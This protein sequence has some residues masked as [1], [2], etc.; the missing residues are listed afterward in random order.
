VNAITF[1][2]ETTQQFFENP[3]N[4]EG[5]QPMYQIPV[6]AYG[7][8]SRGYYIMWNFICILLTSFVRDISSRLQQAG[9]TYQM[10]KQEIHIELLWGSLWE[11]SHL[12]D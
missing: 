4:S 11:R 10:G 7:K 3:P 5:G 8:C 9:N 12:V 6:T 2:Y 1:L